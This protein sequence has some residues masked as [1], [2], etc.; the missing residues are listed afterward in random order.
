VGMMRE[1][2]AGQ[3]PFVL[4]FR[5]AGRRPFPSFDYFHRSA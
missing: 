2:R 4:L 1:R 3:R 5:D